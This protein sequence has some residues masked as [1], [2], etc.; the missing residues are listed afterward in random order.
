MKHFVLLSA[1]FLLTFSDFARATDYPPD[2]LYEVATV[3]QVT[4]DNHLILSGA[5]A[6][7]VGGY[8]HLATVER[9]SSS[10]PATRP[11]RA[12]MAASSS[13]TTMIPSTAG[14][15]RT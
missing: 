8:H 12:R 4:T 6:I 7:H 5:N 14:S 13:K 11:V 9:A 3:A 2:P 1:F 10:K 15:G